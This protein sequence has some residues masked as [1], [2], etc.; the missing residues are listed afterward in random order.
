MSKLCN[1]CSFK[2]IK[3]SCEPKLKEYVWDPEMVLDYYSKSPYD[4][5][6]SP[7]QLAQKTLMLVLLCTGKRPSEIMKMTLDSYEKLDHKFVFILK[8]HTKTSRHG[9]KADRTITIKHFRHK[10]K[11]WPYITLDD[12]IASTACYRKTNFL[13][14]TTTTGTQASRAT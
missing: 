7:I 13:F 5:A 10:S 4:L 1:K 6:L 14:V 12:Y 8:Y 9:V 3:P 11:F 2:D